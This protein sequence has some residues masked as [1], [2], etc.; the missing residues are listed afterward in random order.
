MDPQIWGSIFFNIH[1]MEFI[2]KT[3]LRFTNISSE[4]SREY[5]FPNGN[6][7]VIKKP[8]MLNVSESNGHRLVTKEGICY[9]IK[10]A[11]SWFIKWKTKKGQPHFRK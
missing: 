1:I 11:E 7:L 3:T 10:P 8:F 4:K 6:T 5:N 2:N 9:Y